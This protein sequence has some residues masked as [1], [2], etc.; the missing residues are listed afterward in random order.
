MGT[1]VRRYGSDPTPKFALDAWRDWMNELEAQFEREERI[2][3]IQSL[4]EETRT[5]W[6]GEMALLREVIRPPSVLFWFAN[7]EMDYRCVL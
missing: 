1:L 4:M 6:M 3:R 7:R 5:L 2:A